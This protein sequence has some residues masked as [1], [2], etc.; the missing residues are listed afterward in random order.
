MLKKLLSTPTNSSKAGLP[1]RS[2]NTRKIVS[3]GMFAF[4][5]ITALIVSVLIHIAIE[6]DTL[7]Y[8]TNFSP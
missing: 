8:P 5:I 1:L 6:D 4:V 7:R 3:L 2:T